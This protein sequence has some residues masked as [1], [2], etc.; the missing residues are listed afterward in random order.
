MAVRGVVAAALVARESV[1]STGL[2][3][4][5]AKISFNSSFQQICLFLIGADDKDSVIPSDGANNLR[6]VFVVDSCCDRLG[7][8][9]GGYQNQEVHRLSH[10]KAEALKNFTDSRQCVFI[11]I[12]CCGKGITFRPFVQSQF[13]NISGQCCLSHMK[14]TTCELS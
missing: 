9:G 6:P 7:A 11:I 12:R 5:L 14:P 10:F 1:C 2:I 3:V 4:E 13:V 8:S